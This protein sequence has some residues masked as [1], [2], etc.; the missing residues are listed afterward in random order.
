MDRCCVQSFVDKGFRDGFKL[1]A[2]GDRH[3]CETCGQV[4]VLQRVHEQA[5]ASGAIGPYEFVVT[6]PDSVVH[7]TWQPITH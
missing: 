3:Q 4:Y 2:F 6:N 5:P 1:A 7:Y